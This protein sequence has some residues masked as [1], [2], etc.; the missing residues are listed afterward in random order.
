MLVYFTVLT[1]VVLAAYLARKSESKIVSRLMLGIAFLSM[2]LVAGLRNQYVGTDSMAYI[3]F[4]NRTRTFIDAIILGEDM[5]EHGFWILTWLVH[6]L[7]NQ[8][9]ALFF[10]IALIVISCYQWAIVQYSELIEISFFVFITMGFYLFFFNG[11]RQ[12]I[13]CALYTLAIGQM[14]EKHFFKYTAIVLLAYFFHK[15][16]IMMIPMYFF[17]NRPNTLK[18]NM[19]IMVIGC[20]AMMFIDRIVGFATTIDARY[21]QYGTGGGG[22]GY[23]S[24]A[25]TFVLGVFFLIFRDSVRIGRYQY[26]RFLNMFLFGAMIGV[27]SILLRLDPSGLMRYGEYFNLTAIFIWPIVFKNL[28]GKLQRFIIGYSFVVFYLVMFF[29]TTEAFSNFIPYTFNPIVSDL[30]K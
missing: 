3:Y 11:A 2:V 1:I 22:G 18:N 15:T 9:M 29:L 17:I 14:L 26:D 21:S 10:V 28:T 20:T 19:F 12:G 16:A 4:F 7:S 25:F 13:A 24:F 6:Y 23:Y 27:V 8:Y 5:Q 30:F